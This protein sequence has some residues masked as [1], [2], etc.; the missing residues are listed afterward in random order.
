VECTE[1][2]A[3]PGILSAYDDWM[4]DAKHGDMVVYWRGDL[5]YDRQVVISDNDPDRAEKRKMLSALNVLANRIIDDAKAGRVALT[6]K[7]LGYSTFEYRA[8]RIRE[9]RR[10]NN[11]T[12]RLRD[13]NLVP[14]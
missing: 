13:D 1:L 3:V 4:Q 14:A 6:Q 12:T 7:R 5:Q 10:T 2:E 8:L 11:A 9:L